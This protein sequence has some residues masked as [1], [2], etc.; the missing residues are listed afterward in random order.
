MRNHTEAKLLKTV[1]TAS[2]AAETPRI[3]IIGSGYGGAV[4]ALRLAQAG[5]KVD[6]LE[7]GMDWEKMQPSGGR[8]FPKMT[9][10]NSRAMWFK[11]RTQMPFGR[12]FNIP[13]VD[14][15]IDPAAGVLDVEN[16]GFMNVYVGRGVGGGSLV[17]GGMAVTPSRSYF[18]K[19]LPQL[20]ANEM[21]SKYFP[22]ANAGLGVAE[23]PKDIIATSKYYHF[24][25]TSVKQAVKSGY[26][27]QYVPN[28]YDWDYMRQEG[29]KNVTRSAFDGEVIFGNNHGKKSLPKTILKEALAT[30]NVTVIAQTEVLTITQTPTGGFK[31]QTR[32]IDFNGNVL[33]TQE[34]EYD[35]LIMAAGSIGTNK[36]L[37]KAKNEGTISGLPD[38]T[39]QKWGPNGNI[40]AAR[41]M[42]A[43]TGSYQSGIPAMGIHNWDDSEASVFAEV[44]P[45]P[46]GI[47]LQIGLYLAITNNPQLGNFTWDP[48][49]RR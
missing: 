35:K 19:I 16:F 26:K 48:Q 33:N 2:H 4:A 28:V 43:S 17:N 34:R 12:L 41:N 32:T 1:A 49:P 20:D 14:R 30:G 31:L 10:P 8:V 9:A 23:P 25:R 15:A 3:G 27:T 11:N 44:A 29:F 40:M 18:S 42:N 5:K 37:M 45:F 24:T 6:I 21:F 36:L 13:L 39:G 46:A 38:N 47:D 22:R 7:M